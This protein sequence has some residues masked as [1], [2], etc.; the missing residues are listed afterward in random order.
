MP[1]PHVEVINIDELADVMAATLLA[2]MDADFW[3]SPATPY[4]LD[5]WVKQ[6]D[7]AD[8][9]FMAEAKHGTNNPE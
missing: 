3:N 5:Y 8:E 6:D 1:L 4:G 7:G 9:S 2:A